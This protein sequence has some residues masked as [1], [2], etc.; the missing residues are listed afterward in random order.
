MTQELKLPRKQIQ[1]LG[2]KSLNRLSFALGER[3]EKLDDLANH[4]A[5]FYRPYDLVPRP[6]PFP[7]R[8]KK[9]K[10]P[11]RIDQPY[12]DL[13]F[14]Q[15]KIHRLLLRPLCF[16]PHICGAVQSRSIIDNAS[17]HLGT[18]LLVTID[19]RQCFPSI[20]NKHVYRV[21]KE[22][23]GCSASVAAKLT[24]LTT[25]QR[26]LPQGAPT[27]P[28]LAN[29]F[30]WL[31]DEPIRTLCTELGLAYST[32]IDDLAFSGPRAREIIQP[33]ISILAAEKL[34]V[35]R[36]KIHVMG[37]RAVKLITGARLGADRIRS[38]KELNSRVRSALHKLALA[39]VPEEDQEKYIKGLS[40]QIR[41]IQQLCPQD[42]K[43]LETDLL[44]VQSNLS[45]NS[46]RPGK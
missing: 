38:P 19:I 15:Q 1:Q 35:S 30:V 2:I 36:N 31:I 16:P 18:P 29:L 3:R 28:L 41:H 27:S 23:L 12:G 24:E 39:A 33:A 17:L 21:W 14:V 7:N 32:W 45:K 37:G 22:L 8:R 10:K 4:A 44:A 46:H 11:R 9:G 34:S 13:K 20:S 40:A 43:A 25:F 42:T 26:H 5:S 6:R